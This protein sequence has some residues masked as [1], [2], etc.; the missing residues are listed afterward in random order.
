MLWTSQGPTQNQ[1]PVSPEAHVSMGGHLSLWGHPALPFMFSTTCSPLSSLPSAKT[2][3]CLQGATDKAPKPDQRQ[4]EGN[5]DPLPERTASVLHPI[6]LVPQ[7]SLCFSSLALFSSFTSFPLSES[8]S[9]PAAEGP[10]LPDRTS[11]GFWEPPKVSLPK[12]VL[13][14]G[15]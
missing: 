14:A 6:S 2:H 4:T 13:T 5:T 7:P 10:L 15:N 8:S 12:G 3:L 1:P 9:E 11:N